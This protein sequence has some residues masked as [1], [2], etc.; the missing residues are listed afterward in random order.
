MP[1]SYR[2]FAWLGRVGQVEDDGEDTGGDMAEPGQCDK[3]DHQTFADWVG[4]A[5][6]ICD[7]TILVDEY[8]YPGGTPIN[9]LDFPNRYILELS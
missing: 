9:N 8:S 6:H 3:D 1:F 4:M 7:D 2:A 5:I